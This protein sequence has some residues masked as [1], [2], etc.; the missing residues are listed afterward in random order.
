MNYVRLAAAT[1]LFAASLLVPA[2]ASASQPPAGVFD[3]KC[4][5]S[6]IGPLTPAPLVFATD[7]VAPTS[8]KFYLDG[9]LLSTSTT[10]IETSDG[11]KAKT[12]R[13]APWDSSNLTGSMHQ[14]K[15]EVSDG[16]GNKSWAQS[17]CS[18]PT[19]FFT[20]SVDL[21]PPVLNI[22]TPV[23]G[24]T[25]DATSIT[26]SGEAYDNG[27]R[28][29]H[30]VVNGKTVTIPVGGYKFS[31]TLDFPASQSSLVVKVV[32]TDRGGV[33]IS[34]SVTVRRPAAPAP[35]PSPS[36]PDATSSPES[37]GP[38]ESTSPTAT[39]AVATDTKSQVLGTT[40]QRLAAIG[41]LLVL[42]ALGWVFRARLFRL[43]RGGSTQN[44][45]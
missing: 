23:D 35:T 9:E 43:L 8:V 34:K 25:T 41:V 7:D 27:L 4:S 39:P 36:A 33:G 31:T 26:V 20:F 16:D 14:I 42:I 37:E 21:G 10:A 1:L 32:A 29:T 40:E 6:L 30:V 22:A 18:T 19:P 44:K 13:F 11:G 38:T 15:A 45:R 3:W 17:D 2:L 12:F 24:Q 28:L 5:E